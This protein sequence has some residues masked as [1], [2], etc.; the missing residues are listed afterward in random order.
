MS[1][2][3]LAAVNQEARRLAQADS[4]SRKLRPDTEAG[5]QQE[6]EELLRRD[7]REDFGR[8]SSVIVE[9]DDP[10]ATRTIEG[11]ALDQLHHQIQKMDSTPPYN[12][13]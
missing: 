12:P 10:D 11:A 1:P 2:E 13:Q 9:G 5:V 3:Q 8:T 7:R 4:A 6:S